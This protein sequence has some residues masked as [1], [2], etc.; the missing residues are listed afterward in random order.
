MHPYVAAVDTMHPFTAAAMSKHGTM[1]PY[2]AAVDTMH[3]FTAAVM[4]KHGTLHPYMAS[5]AI[6]ESSRFSFS[7]RHDRNSKPQN[8][9]NL[10]PNA[11]GMLDAQNL[12]TTTLK[13][14]NVQAGEA[15][16]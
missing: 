5:A 16:G 11:L 4:S 7:T 2:T 6:A 9:K 3:P 15:S 13:P 1:H 10:A 12:Q 14:A 8:L